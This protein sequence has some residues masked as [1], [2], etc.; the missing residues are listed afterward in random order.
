MATSLEGFIQQL[1]V[2]YVGRGYYYYV[3]GRVPEGKDPAAIDRKLIEKYGITAKKW[4]RA[5]RKRR[6]LAN[7]QYI[8]YRQT[9]VLL[10]SEGEHVFRR[11]ERESLRDARKVG[12][13]FGGYLVSFRNGHVQV[14]IDPDTYR[15]LKAY[16][17]D[18]ACR[19]RRDAL[20]Q[21]FYRA[22]FE[23]YAPIRRQ[24]F[25]ILREVNR[26]RKRA[27]YDWVPASAIWLKRRVVKPFEEADQA[28][29]AAMPPAPSAPADVRRAYNSD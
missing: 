17:V 25:N 27:G 24:M 26:H 1:A 28:G 2:C 13:R 29:E 18:L 6:G 14:R 12:I 9:F 19:R 10:C 5:D 22:P 11:R 8:R 4:E 23:P 3:L 21:E 20:I 16:Y 7:L 15:Q